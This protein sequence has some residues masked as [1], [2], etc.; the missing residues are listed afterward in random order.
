MTQLIKWPIFCAY[1]S[2]TGYLFLKFNTQTYFLAVSLASSL[3]FLFPS[4][5]IFKLLPVHVFAQTLCKAYSSFR[6]YIHVAK[7]LTPV[8]TREASETISNEYAKLRTT[9]NLGKSGMTQIMTFL[10]DSMFS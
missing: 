9:D 1:N 7:N 3:K 8:L 10:E 5:V 6:K 2:F 4:F